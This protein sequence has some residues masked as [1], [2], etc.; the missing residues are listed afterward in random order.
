VGRSG[1]DIGSAA[2]ARS[3]AQPGGVSANVQTSKTC[4]AQNVREV[5][6]P[7][8]R[9]ISLFSVDHP[10]ATCWALRAAEVNGAKL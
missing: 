9:H 4:P 5:S 8:A 10:P 7:P 3:P 6:T 2:T 1:V